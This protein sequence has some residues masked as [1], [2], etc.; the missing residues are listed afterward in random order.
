M[1]AAAAVVALCLTIYYGNDS[2]DS[3]RSQADT[4]TSEAA[5][6]ANLKVAR[7]AAYVEAGIDGKFIDDSGEE[8]G[9]VKGRS[10]PHLDVTFENR[11]P[12]PSLITKA[13]LRLREAGF[14]PACHPMGSDLAVSMNYEFRLP[15]ELPTK[16]YEQTKEI[17]FMVE[18]NDLDRLT[19]TVG[20]DVEGVTSWYGVADIVFEHDGGKK[21]TLGPIA[22]VDGGSDPE[23][24][25][26][27]DT[28]VIEH[29]TYPS[30]LDE[31]ANLVNHLMGIPDVTVSKELKTLREK[32][33]SMGH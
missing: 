28:W 26:D 29:I 30:C 19:L 12:G 10:G 15:A 21:T 7:V 17:S 18:E 31:T 25:P 9:K 20:P 32:L 6:E 22:V 11:A 5:R 8:V 2:S 13:T 3:G 23:F 27:G 4:G 1:A 16:P 14:F 24:H 33:T